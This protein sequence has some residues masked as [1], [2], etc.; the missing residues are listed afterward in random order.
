MQGDIGP[1]GEHGPP[2][3][4]GEKVK[5]VQ[6]FLANIMILKKGQIDLMPLL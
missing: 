4:R 2:G 3:P 6:K 5:L 1:R